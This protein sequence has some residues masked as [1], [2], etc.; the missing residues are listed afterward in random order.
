MQNADLET[1]RRDLR[2]QCRRREIVAAARTSFLDQGYAGTSMSGLLKTLGGSKGTLW[3][4]FRSK[5]DLFAAVIEDLVESFQ[6]ELGE[7]LLPD[8]QLAP[9]L[10][11]FCA[12]F[13]R[14]LTAP[15]SIATWRLVVA[16]SRRFPEVGQIF[17]EQASQRT[18]RALSAY[19]S[20]HI[21]AGRLRAE[22][23]RQMAEVLIGLCTGKRDQLQASIRTLSDAEFQE[24]SDRFTHIFLRA[25]A[26]FPNMPD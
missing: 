15:E 12:S 9:V 4:Y 16:E 10:K 24:Y 5:E 22:E 21:A 17:Y 2:K 3:A 6:A 25:F 14:K 18:E 20:W 1:S 8:E 13:L 19:L 7:M 26:I 11:A 23:P